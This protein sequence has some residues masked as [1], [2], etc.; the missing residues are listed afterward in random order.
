MEQ[1]AVSQR[2]NPHQRIIFVEPNDV[3][4]KDANNAQQGES[5]TPKYDFVT[6]RT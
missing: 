6:A 4:D 2:P 3:Y 5:L 1:T